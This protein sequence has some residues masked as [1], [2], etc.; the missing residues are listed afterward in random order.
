[1][2]P[3]SV[4]SMSTDLKVQRS[5][6]VVRMLENFPQTGW[7]DNDGQRRPPPFSLGWDSNW[8][9]HDRFWI[10]HKNST[11]NIVFGTT[12]ERRLRSGLPLNIDAI[13]RPDTGRQA[14]AKAPLDFLLVSGRI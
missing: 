3:V 14:F 10:V 5:V 9:R 8:R 4:L 6:E 12:V 1:M 2:Q 7:V 13:M 11:G